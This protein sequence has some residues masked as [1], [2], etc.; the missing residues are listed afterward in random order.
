MEAVLE[1]SVLSGLSVFEPAA[2]P[3]LE[4]LDQH[5]DA[6]AFEKLVLQGVLFTAAR[7][8]IAQSIHEKYRRDHAKDSERHPNVLKS[9]TELSEPYQR[10]NLGQADDIIRKLETIG[11][12]YRPARDGKPDTVRFSEKEIEL[13][14]ESEHERW[15]KEKLEAGYAYGPKLDDELKVHPR[16]VP[17]SEL[18]EDFRQYNREAVAGIPE[19][20]S[21][22]QFEVYRP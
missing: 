7:D 14:A 22:A 10:S 5:V 4:Q 3:P 16:L 9:W 8:A 13:L 1:M 17:W 2:L 6:N 18:P 11:C 20:L 12:R 15:M 19:I 21:D